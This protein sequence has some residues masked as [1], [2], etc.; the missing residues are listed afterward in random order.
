MVINSSC[1][2]LIGPLGPSGPLRI[3]GSEGD[4]EQKLLKSSR[5]TLL[6]VEFLQALGPK[7][8]WAAKC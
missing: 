8:Q 1:K 6:L 5:W 2:V 3:V 4:D 7:A